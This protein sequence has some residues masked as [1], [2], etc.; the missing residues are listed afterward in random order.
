M[1]HRNEPP[2]LVAVN[3]SW[4][5]DPSG[6]STTPP[7]RTAGPDVAIADEGRA[8]KTA[9]TRHTASHR[10]TPAIATRPP[11]VG[12]A[13]EVPRAGPA[14]LPYPRGRRQPLGLLARVTSRW[15]QA[16][17][18]A[19]RCAPS[20]EFRLSVVHALRD[21]SL[22][23][24]ERLI[25]LTV[26][27]TGRYA[28]SSRRFLRMSPKRAALRPVLRGL[29]AGLRG[30]RRCVTAGPRHERRRTRMPR[31]PFLAAVR[32]VPWAQPVMHVR[33]LRTRLYRVGPH[34][35]LEAWLVGAP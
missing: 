6:P 11:F 3:P 32:R 20:T 9:A 8:I 30:L 19:G 31:A 5:V 2:E 13:A 35:L 27:E 22:A 4:D 23:S 18:C 7:P 17:Y 28:G 21:S 29:V 1:T 16:R 24:G 26:P 15:G 25:R 14:S 33:G 12:G 10:R 34:H